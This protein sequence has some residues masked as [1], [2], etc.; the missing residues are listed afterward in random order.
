[1]SSP[2]TILLSTIV[3]AAILAPSAA[4]AQTAPAWLPLSSLN[5]DAYEPHS[6]YEN[7]LDLAWTIPGPACATSMR[8]VFGSINIEPDARQ[9]Y[10]WVQLAGANGVRLQ[11]IAGVYS[12]LTSVAVPGNAIK[13]S[14]HSDSSVTRAGYNI[15]RVEVQGCSPCD[16]AT[17]AAGETCVEQQVVCVTTPC[18][19]VAV[20]EPATNT[21]SADTEC[22]IGEL[23]RDG[24]CVGMSCTQQYEPVCGVDGQTYGNACSAGLAHVAV[25]HVGEC[26]V[27]TTDTECAIGELCRSGRCVRMACTEQYQ[28]VCGVDGRTYGN[29]CTAGLAH[30]AVAYAGECVAEPVAEGD[31]CAADADCGSGLVCAGSFNMDEGQCADDSSRATYVGTGGAIPDN[32]TVGISSRVTASGLRSV[33]VDIV[34]NLRITHPY[35]GDLRVVLVD[36]NGQESVI[37]NRTGGSAD[38]LVL[39]NFVVRGNSM[40]DQVNGTWTLRVTDLARQDVGRIDSWSL[41][42]GSRWD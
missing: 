9:R 7:N 21:C 41:L 1:M 38:N 12:S 19:P 25:A 18:N 3:A 37:H 28:P 33:P 2:R 23:C 15:A 29:A 27:C 26:N 31:L 5:V 10:D 13:L 14:F 34:L 6:P 35:R 17:C 24:A 39:T 36:P 11:R 20:C 4:D 32:S 30:V 22:A 8:I 16:L 40:D 42:L